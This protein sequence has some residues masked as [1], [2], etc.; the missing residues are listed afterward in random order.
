MLIYSFMAYILSGYLLI[1]FFH[2]S[3]NEM[4]LQF[5]VALNMQ[6]HG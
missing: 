3:R 2:M 1:I 6:K 5:E 4:V